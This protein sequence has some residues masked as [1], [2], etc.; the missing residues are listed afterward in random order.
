MKK[1]FYRRT[2]DRPSVVAAFWQEKKRR[3]KEKMQKDG[4]N[5]ASTSERIARRQLLPGRRRV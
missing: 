3:G 1:K 4:I 5:E 2:T